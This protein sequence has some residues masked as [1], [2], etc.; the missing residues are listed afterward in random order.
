MIFI[1]TQHNTNKVGYQNI[2]AHR[3][4]FCIIR[5]S[6][7]TYLHTSM[8]LLLHHR[9][10]DFYEVC[11]ISGGKKTHSSFQFYS[12]IFII[13]V[14][15]NCHHRCPVYHFAFILFMSM[16]D[17]RLFSSHCTAHR[18]ALRDIKTTKGISLICGPTYIRT[19]HSIQ[20]SKTR[21]LNV[22]H[23]NHP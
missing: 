6:T 19:V 3:G 15:R 20:L 4:H 22:N 17:Q 14:F 10:L 2:D 11:M 16:I 18:L 23:K 21:D 5:S 1:I 8:Q 9:Y 12:F 13:I 7:Y